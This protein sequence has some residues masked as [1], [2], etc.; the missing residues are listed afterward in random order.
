MTQTRRS[1]LERLLMHLPILFQHRQVSVEALFLAQDHPSQGCRASSPGQRLA[2]FR[3][4]ALRRRSVRRSVDCPL[5]TLVS[6]SFL[7]KFTSIASLTVL[8]KSMLMLPVGKLE[9]FH[10]KYCAYHIQFSGT[11]S[12]PG[13]PLP[14]TAQRSCWGSYCSGLLGAGLEIEMVWYYSEGQFIQV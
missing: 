9:V 6:C 14:P 4:S 12:A 10:S 8:P 2:T 11:S 13:S 3:D 5:V 1:T 7:I